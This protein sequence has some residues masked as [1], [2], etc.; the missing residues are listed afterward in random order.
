MSLPKHTRKLIKTRKLSTYGQS[1]CWY[2]HTP[3]YKRYN[4]V[5]FTL[6]QAMKAQREVQ[7]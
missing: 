2:I 4:K 1:I 7:I 5:K 3:M 6:E